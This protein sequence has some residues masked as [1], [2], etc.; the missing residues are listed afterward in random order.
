MSTE[1]GNED[2]WFGV[3]DK[4][5]R[6]RIQDRLAQRTR[7]KRLRENRSLAT[8]SRGENTQGGK[9]RSP[10]S[11]EPTHVAKETEENFVGDAISAVNKRSSRKSLTSS[12]TIA[13]ERLDVVVYATDAQAARRRESTSASSLDRTILPDPNTSVYAAL[14]ANGVLLGLQCSQCKIDKSNITVQTIPTSLNPT[15]LQLGVPHPTFIDRFPFQ[16]FRDNFIYFSVLIDVEQF[17]SD[18]FNLPSFALTP[19][20]QSWDPSVWRI[21][22]QFEKR[23]GYLFY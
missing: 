1:L 20:G 3:E 9:G 16:K 6:K 12:E 8:K 17:L 7:R 4:R 18:L 19:G 13:S 2:T 23:W 22:P 21:G 11:A 5:L 14:F 15:P 10:G